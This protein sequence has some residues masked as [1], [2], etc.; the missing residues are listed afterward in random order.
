MQSGKGAVESKKAQHLSPSSAA[1]QKFAPQQSQLHQFLDS[2]QVLLQEGRQVHRP[3][4]P[5]LL[6][7]SVSEIMDN[8]DASWFSERDGRLCQEP[9]MSYDASRL[10]AGLE[11]IANQLGKKFDTDNALLGGAS[12]GWEPPC[13]GDSASRKPRSVADD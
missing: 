2:N 8:L 11:V 13:S 1:T 6:D 5:L 9:T 7:E 12:A 10:R 4:E 3:I